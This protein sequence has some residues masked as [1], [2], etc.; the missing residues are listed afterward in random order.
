[1]QV[2][3]RALL[4]VVCAVILAFC[5]TALMAFNQYLRLHAP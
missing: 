4:I 2:G 5:G 3:A 1:M